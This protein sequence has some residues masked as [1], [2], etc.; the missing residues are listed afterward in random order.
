MLASTP[1]RLLG[2]SSLVVGGVRYRPLRADADSIYATRVSSVR[3]C[4]CVCVCVCVCVW[5]I[6]GMAITSP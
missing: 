3:L 4:P 1:E 5:V 6:G 2:D